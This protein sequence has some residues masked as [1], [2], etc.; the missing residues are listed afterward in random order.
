MGGREGGIGKDSRGVDATDI[1]VSAGSVLDGGVR[2]R[3]PG[4]DSGVGCIV[5]SEE[6][7]VL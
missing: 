2:L 7:F 6:E 1:T 5:A 3:S 4:C